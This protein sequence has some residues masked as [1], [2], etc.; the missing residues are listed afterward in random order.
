MSEGLLIG[1]WI[2]TGV[3]SRERATIWRDAALAYRDGKVVDV[4]PIAEMRAKYPDAPT[5]GSPDHAILPGFVNSHHHVGLTPLQL[6]SPDYALEL[7]FASRISGRAVDL[8][9]D[10]LYS[11]FEMIASGITTV[12]HIHGW[13]PGPLSHIHGCS[14][15]V[16][17]AYRTIGM[18]ASYC[19]A[20]REQNRLV[21]EADEDFLQ[22]LPTETAALLAPHLAKQRL[23][24]NDYLKLFDMLNG[25]NAGQN[26]TRI[27]L[28]PANLHWCTDEGLQALKQKADT[29]HVPMH[30][31]LLETVYQKEYARRRTGTTA[32]K[33]LDKLGLLGPGLT[34]GHGVWLTEDDIEIAAATGTCICHNCSSNLRLRSG[35]APVNVFE[36]KGVTVGMGLDEA[37]INE[38]RDMLQEMRLALRVHRVPGMREDDVPSCPQIL[39]MATEHGAMT[40]AFGASIGKLEPGRFADAVLIN[41]KK[42]FYPYQDDD[43]PMLD[44]LIQR[45]KTDAVDAVFVNGEMIYE[46]GRFTHIDRDKVLAEIAEAMSRPRTEA[47]MT[48]R[49]LRRQVFPHVEAFYRDYLTDMPERQ[50]FYA[51][52]SRT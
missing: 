13:I 22:R 39:K 29:A 28:A 32:V 26:L 44:A 14:T 7:W 2:V 43:I 27:Q 1:G 3:E 46:H 31:H 36:A 5:Y 10:T 19:F 37:G 52:S 48:S 49:E 34:L 35:V 33:H 25:E 4:G 45:A 24:F 30:M 16:L 38:D 40:T 23:P 15:K 50:P 42:A 41:V 21:Y 12:Q 51:P 47:E 6:G 20:V 17:D 8:Y 18:R 9:L 11:A